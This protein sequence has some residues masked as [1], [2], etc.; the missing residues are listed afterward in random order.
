MS[1]CGTF[2]EKEVTLVESLRRCVDCGRRLREF[3]DLLCY[4]CCR[5]KLEAVLRVLASDPELLAQV[6]DGY[7]SQEGLFLT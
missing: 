3:Q 4:D 5:H 6:R 2:S 7:E 1:R